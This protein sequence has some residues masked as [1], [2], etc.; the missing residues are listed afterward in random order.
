[1]EHPFLVTLTKSGPVGQ[2]IL[3]SLV[4]LSFFTWAIIV[5]KARLLSRAEKEC[6][7]F[8][9]RFREGGAEWL[10]R[11]RV[12]GSGP[13]AALFESGLAEFSA[14]RELVPPGQP[15]DSQAT[16]RLEAALEV[17][18]AETITALE[19]GH[20]ILAIGASMSPF[21]GL[22]GTTWGIMNEFRSMGL[23]GSVG[24]EAVA[25]GVEEELVKNVAGFAVAINDVV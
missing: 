20:V 19:R 22:L 24:I 25:P 10:V 1:M 8:L 13:L 6:R 11:G 21:V 7:A 3:A 12:P 4:V 16:A 14:Q 17:E 23:E 18:A 15:L 9:A 2:T 5:T